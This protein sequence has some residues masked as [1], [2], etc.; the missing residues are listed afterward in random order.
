MLTLDGDRLTFR[1]RRRSAA[2]HE[3]G[4]PLVDRPQACETVRTEIRHRGVVKT[5]DQSDP[6]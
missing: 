5:F 3:G 2:Y 6:G 1:P 4:S